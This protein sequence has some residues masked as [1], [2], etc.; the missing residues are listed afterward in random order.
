[1]SI[2]LEKLFA[3]HTSQLLCEIKFTFQ[4]IIL[5]LRMNQ[6]T[7]SIYNNH[8]RLIAQRTIDFRHRIC[9]STSAAVRSTPGDAAPW[10]WCTAIVKQ[11]LAARERGERLPA[12]RQ[13]RISGSR[14]T[15]HGGPFDLTWPTHPLGPPPRPTDSTSSPSSSPLL[16]PALASSGFYS[17]PAWAAV[18][19]PSS[20]P[21]SWPLC[22]LEKHERVSGGGC[23]G[24]IQFYY[25]YAYRHAYAVRFSP[26][27]AIPTVSPRRSIR[28]FA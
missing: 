13:T 24:F 21:P 19:S 4:E 28:A 9:E 27:N 18:D 5:E 11:I 26:G 23:G 3:Q 16:P 6:S 2:I 1:M 8:V 25:Y 20:P 14:T 15:S 12:S 10:G 17:G 7:C 22:I